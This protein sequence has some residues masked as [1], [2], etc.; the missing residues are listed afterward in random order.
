MMLSG[1][2][3]VYKYVVHELSKRLKMNE[4]LNKPFFFFLSILIRNYGK[5]ITAA[6]RDWTELWDNDSVGLR[7]RN[8]YYS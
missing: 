6:E 7:D 2:L 8:H 1:L 3:S 4:I 5:P